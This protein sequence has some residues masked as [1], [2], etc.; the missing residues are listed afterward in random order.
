MST[1]QSAVRD[2]VLVVLDDDQGVAELL[3][4]QQ[5]LDEPA[6]VTLVQPDR[7][8]VEDVE[9]ADEARADLGG[10]PDALGLATGQRGRGPVEREVVEADVEQEAEPGVDLLEH[11]LAIMP[12]AGVELQPVVRNAAQSPIDSRQTSAMDRSASV[13]ARISGLSRAPLQVGQGTSRM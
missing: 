8:L 3:E 7:R 1:T 6:V 13:T 5:R 2:R 4:P 9:H 12:L 10:Q 11:P